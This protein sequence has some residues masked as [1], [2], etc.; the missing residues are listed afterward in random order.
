MELMSYCYDC[1]KPIPEGQE[2]CGECEITEF[3]KAIGRYLGKL[4]NQMLEPILD[5]LKARAGR[6]VKR[7][8]MENRLV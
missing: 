8:F 6:D 2:F 4:A 3:A 5:E 1:I 7:V